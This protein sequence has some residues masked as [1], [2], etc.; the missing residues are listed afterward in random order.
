ML[1]PKQTSRHRRWRPVLC[2]GDLIGAPIVGCAE[3][4]TPGTKPCTMV[5]STLPGGT[6]LKAMAGGRPV[7]ARR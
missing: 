4:P 1:I 3:P 2:E 7:H 6:S 5:V